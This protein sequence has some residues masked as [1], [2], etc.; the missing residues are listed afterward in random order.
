MDIANK[1]VTLF[2]PSL[3]GGGAERVM[4]LLAN[5]LAARGCRV[6]LLILSSPG[7]Y[8]EE[9]SPDVRLVSLGVRR[10]MTCLPA[11]VRYLRKARP[12]YVIS[13][14]DYANV[15]ALLA[16]RLARTGT[17]V[18]V[19]EHNTLSLTLQL[20]PSR[21]LRMMLALMRRT[22][23]WAARVVAVSNGVADDLALT[24]GLK[25]Q[26]IVTI[27]N[28]VITPTMLALAQEPVEHPW[29]ED[30]EVPVIL[31][32]GRFTVA[33]DFATLLH[34][35]AALRAERPARLVLL[36][37]GPLRSQ[38]E[39]LVEQLGL[40]EDVLMPGFVS[41]PYAWM[42]EASVFV[43]SSAYEGLGNVLIEAMACGAP[44]VSTDCKSGPAE[45]LENGKWGRLVPVANAA[46]L[47]QA[48]IRTLDERGQPNARERA[49]EFDSDSAVAGYA[50]LLATV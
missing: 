7:Q 9:V 24:L 38:L 26:E 44:V 20:N 48:I 22:Y 50:A 47:S 2:V 15:F 39:M 4:I 29:L 14:L 8:V 49:L 27:Y 16:N 33:K 34:A 45:I 35:F 12:D 36:G 41:N 3:G 30:A 43:L 19:T 42:R 37:E 40:R 13:A 28:P 1:Q 32:V 11:L 5:G 21:K 6:E 31:G 46:A 10:V 23:P 17:R 25:R 18:V